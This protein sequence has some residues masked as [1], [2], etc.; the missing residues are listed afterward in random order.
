[1]VQLIGVT[2]VF[3]FWC[4]AI[5][6]LEQYTHQSKHTCGGN[7][8]ILFPIDHLSWAVYIC[9]H[10]C[11]RYEPCVG[12]TLKDETTH[13]LCSIKNKCQPVSTGNSADNVYVKSET[14]IIRSEPVLSESVLEVIPNT[15][16]T[17]TSIG[18]HDGSGSDLDCGFLC[19]LHG[20]PCIGA[21]RIKNAKS[22]YS[23]YCFLKGSFNHVQVGYNDNIIKVHKNP[24]QPFYDHLNSFT[25]YEGEICSVSHSVGNINFLHEYLCAE[26]CQA[27]TYCVAFT[28]DRDAKSCGLKSVCNP[29]NMQPS[30]QYDTY[31]M[32]TKFVCLEHCYT[33]L[34]DKL[35]SKPD[36]EDACSERGQYLLTLETEEEM[37]TLLD[38]I[39]QI[40]YVHLTS[41]MWLSL[42][43]QAGKWKMSHTESVSVSWSLPW[44]IGHPVDEENFALLNQQ[45]VKFVSGNDSTIGYAVCETKGPFRVYGGD[46]QDIDGVPEE[47]YFSPLFDINEGTCLTLGNKDPVGGQYTLELLNSRDIT[48]GMLVAVY[49]KSM[50]QTDPGFLLML[51]NSLTST[52][53]GKQIKDAYYQHCKWMYETKREGGVQEWLFHCQ[54]DGACSHVYLKIF[55]A[56]ELCGLSNWY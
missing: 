8:R 41:P 29:D 40:L 21:D 15:L 11:S 16:T 48:G 5:A 25:R 36:A 52:S 27:I 10:L 43:Q 20:T 54:C 32:K 44:E 56:V 33:F 7:D 17:D 50:N 53:D 45:T 49:G 23:E 2:L 22:E 31:I 47:S 38:Y 12:F 9:E 1:M 35:L 3:H 42:D 30:S 34:P 39:S 24:L 37:T 4:V 18:Y 51:A 46:G 55:K 6:S 13:K 14:T 28:I 26:M 19:L